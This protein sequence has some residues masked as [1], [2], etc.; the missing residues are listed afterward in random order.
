[1]CN[2]IV[3]TFAKICGSWCS[4]DLTFDLIQ[5]DPAAIL[6]LICSSLPFGVSDPVTLVLI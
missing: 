2:V 1:M 6:V 5:L 3:V 4:F